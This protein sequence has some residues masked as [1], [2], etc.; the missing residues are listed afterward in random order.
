MRCFIITHSI[1][2]CVC[3]MSCFKCFDNIPFF[4]VCQ[5]LLRTVKSSVCNSG[6]NSG[7]GDHQG[8][9]VIIVK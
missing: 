1:N 7:P 9:T 4:S 5:V 2:M 3:D 6:W 8:E